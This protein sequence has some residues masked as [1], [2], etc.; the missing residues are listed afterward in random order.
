MTSSNIEFKKNYFLLI[1]QW[2]RKEQTKTL[3]LSLSLLALC[4]ISHTESFSTH[5]QSTLVPKLKNFWILFLDRHAHKILNTISYIVAKHTHNVNTI[6]T[7]GMNNQSELYI[8]CCVMDRVFY[9][10]YSRAR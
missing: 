8:S 6:F 7:F 2:E 9:C 1:H 3:S 10:E 5:S 4:A